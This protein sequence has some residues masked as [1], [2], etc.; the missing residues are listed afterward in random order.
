MRFTNPFAKRGHSSR[1][2]RSNPVRPPD[3]FQ[4]RPVY[5]TREEWDRHVGELVDCLP[6]FGQ[7]V[8]PP[9]ARLIRRHRGEPLHPEDHRRV[10]L[11]WLAGGSAALVGR[12]VNVSRRSVYNVIRRFVYSSDPVASMA[13]WHDLGLIACLATPGCAQLNSSTVWQE[14]IC[15]ICHAR[16]TTYDWEAPRLEVGTVFRPAPRRHMAWVNAN[17]SAGF[18]Q[19]HL[20][21]HYWLNEF[22]IP[23]GRLWPAWVGTD[24]WSSVGRWASQYVEERLRA[25]ESATA[26]VGSKVIDDH[27]Q[28]RSWRLQLLESGRQGFIPP[29]LRIPAQRQRT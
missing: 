16:V 22:P 1:S 18:A 24:A 11:S 8:P 23:L 26:A 10:L 7:G 5:L 25:R 19:G 2:R 3:Q 14:V 21:L 9:P 20:I 27:E 28:W 12:R 17:R 29:P 15:L 6:W 4:G 13:A